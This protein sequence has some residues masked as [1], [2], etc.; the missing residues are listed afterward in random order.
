MLHE[1][2]NIFSIFVIIYRL[3]YWFC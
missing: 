2:N 1:N 3:C